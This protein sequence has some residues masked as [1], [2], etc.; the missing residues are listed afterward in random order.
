MA[1]KQELH[2]T[3]KEVTDRYKEVVEA[4]EGLRQYLIE[5]DSHFIPDDMN[6]IGGILRRSYKS[7]CE[8]FGFEPRRIFP[9]GMIV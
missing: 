8:N 9:R 1:R 4:V 7:T 6:D 3:L 5:K 2:V